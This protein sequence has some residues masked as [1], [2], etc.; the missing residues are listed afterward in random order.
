MQDWT[1]LPTKTCVLY[2]EKLVDSG[3]FSDTEAHIIL[4]RISRAEPNTFGGIQRR[5]WVPSL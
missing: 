5:K 3:P 4:H 1:T 2:G